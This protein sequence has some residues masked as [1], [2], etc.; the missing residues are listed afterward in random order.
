M[1]FSKI[2]CIYH[3][4]WSLPLCILLFS[5]SL[6]LL[7]PY[8]FRG[9]Q[10]VSVVS[11][12]EFPVWKSRDNLECE[13]QESLQWVPDT[14]AAYWRLRGEN[15]FSVTDGKKLEHSMGKQLWPLLKSKNLWLVSWKD[16]EVFPFRRTLLR[17]EEAF[18]TMVRM[19]FGKARTYTGVPVY[20]S[21]F[22]SWQIPANMYPARQQVM[23]QALGSF[24]IHT[25][26][27]AFVW[28]SEWSSRWD[29]CACLSLFRRKE[30]LYLPQ[31][32]IIHRFKG[33]P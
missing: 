18:G 13:R 25:E 9:R 19:V 1:I 8:A 26:D 5:P 33:C 10:V 11:S 7:G 14:Q 30:N 31:L 2:L 28:P 27:L 32:C 6:N 21:Q 17:W 20:E 22:C 4:P 12:L 16:C 23:T 15:I 24:S 29:L 3:L